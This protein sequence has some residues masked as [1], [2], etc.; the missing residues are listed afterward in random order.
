MFRYVDAL[1]DRWMESDDRRPVLVRGARQIG[2]SFSILHWAN[3]YFGKENVLELNLEERPQFKEVFEAELDPDKILDRINSLTNFD[4]RKPGRILFIDEIQTCPAAIVALRYFYEKRPQ[5]PVI[6]AGS[7]VEFALRKVSVPVGRI[8]YLFM[9]PLSFKEFLIAV[10]K[11]G[12]RDFLEQADTSS[13]VP[14]VIHKELLS[15]LRLYMQVGGMPKA[16]HRFASTRDL[17]AVSKEHSL[18]LQTYRE[19]F[20]KYA[21]DSQLEPLEMVFKRLPYHVGIN[22]LIYK[23][24]DAV[25]RGEKIKSCI[26]L[27]EKAKVM[28]RIVSTNATKLPLAAA[29]KPSFFKAIFVDI[30]LLQHGL[31]FDWREISLHAD[32]SQVCEGKFAEQFVGQELLAARS[33][34]T[35]YEL[36][37]WDRPVHGS[38][39]EVDYIIEH[40]DKVVPLEVKSGLKGSLKGLHRYIKEFRPHKA[41]VASQRNVERL[42]DIHWLPLYLVSRL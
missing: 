18:I 27:L 6:A 26:E 15:L 39:A 21:R 35:L 25:I 8:E 42:D 30:G 40:E 11:S 23:N 19:D 5:L 29:E 4:L 41:L 34:N 22:R 28:A 10:D 3:K 1:L 16:V 32:L 36:H 20:G 12:L 13:A 24:F 2:K 7:L 37:Y 31:G 9:Q 33:A 14:E 38:E 17:A